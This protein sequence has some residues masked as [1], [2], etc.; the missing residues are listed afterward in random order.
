M[1]APRRHRQLL[2]LAATAAFLVA[3]GEVAANGRFPAAGQLVVHPVDQD[4]I[5]VQTTYGFITSKDGGVTW[6]WTCEEAAFYSGILDPPLGLT[7]DGTLIG[8]VFDG[9]IVSPDGCSYALVGGDLADKY[10]IDVSVERGDPSRAIAVSSNGMSNNAFLTQLWQS[11]DDGATWAQ[12]G[13]DLP[14]DFLALTA[15]VA[16]ADPDRVYLSGLVPEGGSDYGGYVQ[17][18]DDRGA[19]WQRF[20]VPGTSLQASPFLAGIAAG[21]PDVVFVRLTGPAGKLLR[22]TN[23]GQSW[24]EIFSG[25]GILK[26]FALSPDGSRMVVGGDGDGIWRASLDDAVFEKVSEVGAQCL[27]WT[28]RGL[29][30]CGR[31]GQD[32]FTVGISLDEGETFEALHHLSCLEGPIDCPAETEVGASCDNAWPATAATIQASTCQGG[33]GGGGEGGS[34]EPVPGGGGDGCCTVAPGG[35]SASRGASAALAML[36]MMLLARRRL[37]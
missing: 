30:A 21:D 13:V 10:V 4:V 27:T 20:E 1:R 23:G 17:R 31:E 18:S 3:S 33:S 24:E 32:G 35:G 12:A 11:S 26:G 5:V 22:S 28:E 16:P 2:G 8:G 6:H 14:T 15:D 34:T 37:R 9:L 29:Y 7:Q 25:A 36:G 19:T